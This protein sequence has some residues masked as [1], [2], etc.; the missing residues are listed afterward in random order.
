MHLLGCDYRVVGSVLQVSEPDTTQDL[1]MSPW[2]TVT[3]KERGAIG[4]AARVAIDGFYID[5]M[6][7]KL[8]A[9]SPV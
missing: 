9:L 3:D 5:E 1:A 7:K 2:R 6:R 4:G 8:T